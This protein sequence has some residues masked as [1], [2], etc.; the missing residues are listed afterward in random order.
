MQSLPLFHRLYGDALSRLPAPIVTIHDVRET[1][2]WRGEAEVAQG[3]SLAARLLCRL[4]RLPPSGGGVPL[5]V[6]MEPDGAGEIWR[7]RFAGRPMTTR[8]VPGSCREPSRRH[9]RR[10]SSLASMP[11]RAA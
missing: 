9:W 2:T 6:V 3:T 7:R 1:R 4:F 8:L 5:V 11:T 10:R